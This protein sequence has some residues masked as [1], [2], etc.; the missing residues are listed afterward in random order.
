MRGKLKNEKKV[1]IILSVSSFFERRERGGRGG[2]CVD[3]RVE[4]CASD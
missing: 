4:H 2:G 3:V 1:R